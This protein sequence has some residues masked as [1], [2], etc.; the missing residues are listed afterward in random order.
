MIEHPH[1]ITLDR[2]AQRP[3]SLA[4]AEA[5]EAGAAAIR[6]L[7]AL[8]PH[9]PSTIVGNSYAQLVVGY[10]ELIEAQDAVGQ[11][12]DLGRFDL[13]AAQDNHRA[14]RLARYRGMD[15]YEIDAKWGGR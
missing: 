5:I 7:Q 12:N 14:E 11:A 6:A 3:Q 13:A 8:R 15:S 4:D 9:H 1:A 10:D 2:L